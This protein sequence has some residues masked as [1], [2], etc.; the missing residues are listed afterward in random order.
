MCI[1]AGVSLLNPYA[2][3]V[4][5]Y[6]L[7]PQPFRFVY[8][9]GHWES[10]EESILEQG[11]YVQRPTKKNFTMVREM[12]GQRVMDLIDNGIGVDEFK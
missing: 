6:H 10:A 5:C 3:Q 11:L 2:K 7:L 4:F 1:C 9:N 8:P 12:N